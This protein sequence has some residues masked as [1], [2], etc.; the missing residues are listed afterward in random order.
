MGTLHEDQCAF[1]VVSCSFLLIMGNIMEVVEKI[2]THIL[3]V[4]TIFLNRALYEI[5]GK[6]IVELDWVH[7]MCIHTTCW[8]TKATGTHNHPTHLPNSFGSHET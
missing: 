7:I 4:I 3:C 2:K 6:N 8:M 5:M 1:V